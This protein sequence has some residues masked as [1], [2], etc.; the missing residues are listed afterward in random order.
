MSILKRKNSRVDEPNL[1]VRIPAGSG[2][3]EPD[4][5]RR[6]RLQLAVNPVVALETLRR[7]AESGSSDAM[8]AL[9]DAYLLEN[10]SSVDFEMALSWHK[11][12]F[13][14]GLLRSGYRLGRIFFE[15][16]D[17]RS[18]IEYWGNCSDQGNT[19][20]MYNLSA[21]YYRGFGVNRDWKMSMYFAKRGMDLGSLS[22][23]GQYGVLLLKGTS[24]IFNR[25]KGLAIVFVAA[26]EINM[27]QREER[28]S[29]RRKK[30]R[31]KY[32]IQ[33]PLDFDSDRR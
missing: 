14:A 3:S 19:E 6:A 8:Y 4:D 28:A 11:R 13:E 10:I 25:L 21:M 29:K 12:A 30:L 33:V 1:G 5:V 26:W 22:C 32:K 31:A 15:Q 20:A 24:G 27:P 18:A 7:L 23:K 16:K 2:K 9:G 17:Y